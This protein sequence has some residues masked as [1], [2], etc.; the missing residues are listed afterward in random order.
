MHELAMLKGVVDAVEKVASQAGARGVKAVHLRVGTRSGAVPEALEGTWPIVTTAT[1]LAQTK[2]VIEVV[3]AA[4]WCE[5][6]G[7]EQPIDEFFAWTCPVCQTP[8]ANLVAGREFE[9]VGVDL[10][11]TPI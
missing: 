10:D 5:T 3:Q 6:C 11:E 7:G 2:L 1:S 9:L 8:T 4:V